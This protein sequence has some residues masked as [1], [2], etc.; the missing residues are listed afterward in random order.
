DL[1][2]QA[3]ALASRNGNCFQLQL[4]QPLSPVIRCDKTILRTILLNLIDNAAKYTHDGQIKVH[5]SSQEAAHG[6]S[7]ELRFS[8]EDTGPGIAPDQQDR[9]FDPFYRGHD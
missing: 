8:I 6:E 3:R 5:V 4:D 1:D 2:H 9:L 7:V